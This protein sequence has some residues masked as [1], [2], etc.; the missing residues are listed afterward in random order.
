MKFL[1]SASHIAESTGEE[2]IT[3]STFKESALLVRVEGF[4]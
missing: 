4:I 1:H 2:N 3:N